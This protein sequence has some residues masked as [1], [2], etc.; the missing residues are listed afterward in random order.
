VK[1]TIIRTAVIGG[2]LAY[3]VYVPCADKW[4]ASIWRGHTGPGFDYYN[5][6]VTATQPQALREMERGWE[7]WDAFK[8]HRDKAER[9]ALNIAESVFPELA[10]YR[11][12]GNDRLPLLWLTNLL[13]KGTKETSAEFTI[14][15]KGELSA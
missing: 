10:K 11:A 8:I 9:I 3:D 7:R 6:F 5:D 4:Q 15:W 14:D 2:G 13:P 1:V 12:R